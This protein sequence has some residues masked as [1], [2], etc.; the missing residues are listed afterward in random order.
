MIAEH[1]SFA[2]PGKRD[3]E[4]AAALAAGI[5]VNLESASE[6]ERLAQR[7]AAAGRRARRCRARQSRISN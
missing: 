4:L 7:C 3:A 5:T 1:I 6:M 2:G